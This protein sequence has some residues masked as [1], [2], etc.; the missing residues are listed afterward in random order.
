MHAPM[1]RTPLHLQTPLFDEVE[2]SQRY[3]RRLFLKMECFQPTGSS[4]FAELAFYANDGST[5]V[6]G[7]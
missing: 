1:I 2:A 4:K 7:H 6:H 5:V 3:G